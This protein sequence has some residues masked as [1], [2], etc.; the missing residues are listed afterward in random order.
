MASEYIKWVNYKRGTSVEGKIEGGNE[1]GATI[2]VARMKL[3]GGAHPG[4]YVVNSGSRRVDSGYTGSSGRE[5]KF[6]V[7]QIATGDERNFK[8]VA[9][10]GPFN[11]SNVL[12]NGGIPV[13]AGFENNGYD[14]S[15][16][17]IARAAVSKVG[18]LCGKVREGSAASIPFGTKEHI[19]TEYEVLVYTGPSETV[20]SSRSQS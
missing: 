4:K 19:F 15:L 10:T 3:N 18:I 5:A 11:K 13:K 1:Y 2:F 7:F 8:W 9:Q 17:Y 20:E 16:F 12:V 14:L 6:R